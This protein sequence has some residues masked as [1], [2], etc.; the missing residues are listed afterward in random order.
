[1]WKLVFIVAAIAVSMSPVDARQPPAKNDRAEKR[2]SGELRRDVERIS[3]EIYRE[4]SDFASSRPS[5]AA[6]TAAKK[7]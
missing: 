3:K 4:R 2:D 7:R 5:F 6:G 1:M